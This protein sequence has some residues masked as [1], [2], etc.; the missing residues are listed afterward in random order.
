MERTYVYIK[1]ICV[2][3]MTYERST[4]TYNFRQTSFGSL[5]DRAVDELLLDLGLRGIKTGLEECYVP[6][7]RE[8][9]REILDLVELDYYDR[10]ELIRRLHGVVVTD[11]IWFGEMPDM[12]DWYWKRHPH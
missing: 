10:W 3:E 7:Y 6:P 2:G 11:S 12:G 1:D 9:I 5:Q 4:D 8:N